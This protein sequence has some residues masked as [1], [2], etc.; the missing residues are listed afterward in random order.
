[1]SYGSTGEIHAAPVFVAVLGASK[2]TYIE[3]TWSPQLP[4]WIGSHVRALAFFG[5]RTELWVA[6][7]L[8][9]GVTKAS[10]YEP[11]VTLTTST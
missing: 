7:N 6:D 8:R 4:D 11:D 1:M 2:Y 3:A 9:S 10:R 5:G